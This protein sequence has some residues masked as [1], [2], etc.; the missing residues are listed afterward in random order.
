M[1]LNSFIFPAPKPTYTYEA[2]KDDIIFIPRAK[3]VN[4]LSAHS[5][6]AKFG[7]DSHHIPCWYIK[8]D[9]GSSKVLLYF[10]GNAEDAGVA[11]ELLEEIGDYLKAHVVCVEY[12][13]Y[14]IYA[15]SPEASRIAQD[16]INAYDFIAFECGWG[17]ENVIVMGR[18]IG[19]GPA[20]QVAA[21]KRPC[22]LLLLSPFTSIKGI[23]QSVST[24]FLKLF[25]KERFNNTEIIKKVKC[26][27]LIVH[28]KA[29]K[30]IPHT[31][32]EELAKNCGYT[33]CVLKMPLRMS[34]NEF[35][36]RNDVLVPF[37]DFIDKTG[38]STEVTATT[39]SLITFPA[40]IHFIPANFPK[41]MKPSAIWRFLR[42]LLQ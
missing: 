32:S 8:Y 9:E 6:A 33:N 1:E 41:P 36:L 39:K 16:A 18:S 30:L 34:H 35:E 40:S 21:V 7:K 22:A 2:H 38:I 5:V 25:V 17:E 14:G 24:K 10:H 3:I 23:I 42:N 31:H 28:G 11:K 12:P 37:K 19:T 29:D 20:I 27:T 4:G 13:G 26:P 15:G